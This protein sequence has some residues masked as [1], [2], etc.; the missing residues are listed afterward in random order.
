[1]SSATKAV[2]L[3]QSKHEHKVR[4][5]DRVAHSIHFLDG[6]QHPVKTS[7]AFSADFSK[8]QTL[9]QF[10]KVRRLGSW[11]L[12]ARSNFPSQSFPVFSAVHAGIYT[13]HILY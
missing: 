9:A 5:M 10:D 7:L 3:S 6:C 13:V 8:V 11:R 1:M 2:A 12:T 4:A